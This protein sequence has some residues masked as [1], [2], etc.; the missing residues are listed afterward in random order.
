MSLPIALPARVNASFTV[1]STISPVP[2]ST[3]PLLYNSF[4]P[5]VC[6]IN[7]AGQVTLL[8]AGQCIVAADKAGDSSFNTAGQS[9]LSFDV[10]RTPQTLSLAPMPSNLMIKMGD[11]YQLIATA[12]PTPSSSAPISFSSLTPTVCTV[13]AQ[14]GLVSF[15]YGGLC[16]VAVDKAGD[17]AYDPAPTLTQQWVVNAIVPG[18]NTWQVLCLIGLL[19]LLATTQLRPR[20]HHRHGSFTSTI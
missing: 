18:L 19:L 1:S 14:T 17:Y 12:S 7:A 15:I 6:S 16:R 9:R 11:T 10:L 2:S 3:A 4:S 20:P 5:T 13:D 8:N